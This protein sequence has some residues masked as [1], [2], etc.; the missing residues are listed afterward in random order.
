MNLHSATGQMVAGRSDAAPRCQGSP[1]V[2]CDAFGQAVIITSPDG[3]VVTW[4]PY[5]ETLYGWTAAEAIGRSILELT[6]SPDSADQAAEVIERL[7]AGES[8]SG[9]FPVRRKDGTSFV[10]FV[11]DTAGP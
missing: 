11:T 10:A 5:A 4:N 7:R 6:P 2:C 9:E 1:I 8:W 3:V